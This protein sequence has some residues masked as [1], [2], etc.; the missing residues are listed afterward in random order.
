V[1]EPQAVAN[2]VGDEVDETDEDVN[3][4]GVLVAM[5]LVFATETSFVI[6]NM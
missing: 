2:F 4:L 5:L 1:P 6:P 3:E